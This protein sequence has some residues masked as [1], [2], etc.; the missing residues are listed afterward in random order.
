MN[1]QL[2]IAVKFALILN[3]IFKKTLK[4]QTNSYRPHETHSTSGKMINLRVRI[5]CTWCSESILAAL[6]IPA[7]SGGTPL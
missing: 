4:V 3:R 2:A 5:S 7:L 1:L 6:T